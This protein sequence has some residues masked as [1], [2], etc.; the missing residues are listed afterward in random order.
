MADRRHRRFTLWPFVLENSANF[1]GGVGSALFMK[2]AARKAHDSGVI[3]PH[4]ISI[5]ATEPP[6]VFP[7]LVGI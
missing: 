2:E 6:A 3:D 1:V 5:G 4:P 7:Q